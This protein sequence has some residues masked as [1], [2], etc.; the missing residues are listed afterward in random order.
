MLEV[1]IKELPIA[2]V[3]YLSGEADA[4][5]CAELVRRLVAILETRPLRL[6]ISL[7]G[8]QH[9]DSRGLGGL[10]GVYRRAQEQKCA[11]FLVTSDPQLRR[12]IEVSGLSNL[13]QVRATEAEA[14]SSE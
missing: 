7:D 9:I 14:L 3:A 6:V 10:V 2:A 1:R 11:F 13:F 8:L 4:R 12:V 5:N